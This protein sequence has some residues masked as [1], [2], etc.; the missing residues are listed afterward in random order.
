MSLNKVYTVTQQE[1]VRM[2]EQELK[3]LCERWGVTLRV[4]V[5]KG[6]KA[7]VYEGVKRF[8]KEVRGVYLIAGSKLPEA[9]REALE[10]KLSK[11]HKE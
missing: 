4:N 10:A 1:V 3:E 9:S 7:P 8:G 2:T 6:R 5:R 11:L